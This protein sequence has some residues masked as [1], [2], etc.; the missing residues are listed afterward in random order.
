MGHQVV[1]P[2]N[3]QKCLCFGTR[4]MGFKERHLLQDIR[5]MC[6]HFREHSKISPVSSGDTVVE[7]CNLH[8]CNSTLYFEAH[9]DEVTYMWIA[10]APKG[11]SIK[12]RIGNIH[13]ADQIR[14][15]GNCLKFSRPLL[16]FDKEFDQ[17]PHL[18]VARSLLQTAFNVP[19]HHPKSKPF[20]DHILCF[21]FLDDHIWFRNYQIVAT[22][23]EPSLMEVGPRFTLHPVAIFNGCCQG[24]VLWRN[25]NVVPPSEERRT[26]KERQRMKAD[27]NER[28]KEVTKDHRTAVGDLPIDPLDNI[29]N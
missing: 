10:Q 12:L 7:L 23:G 28:L 8:H 15:V 24:S 20:V 14:M 29:F 1:K 4:N 9:R 13:T 11:P 5:D 21:Y 3:L 16:H 2:T 6:P 25:P 18:R 19:R 27:E 22:D 17:L 26:R